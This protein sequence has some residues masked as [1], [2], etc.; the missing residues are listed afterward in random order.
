[1]T[2]VAVEQRQAR[3][4]VKPD[5]VVRAGDILYVPS[6]PAR[7]TLAG[8]VKGQLVSKGTGTI[9]VLGAAPTFDIRLDSD[10]ANLVPTSA[11]VIVTGPRGRW[12]AHIA[13]ATRSTDGGLDL[14][15]AG[16]SFD[17]CRERFSG[18]GRPSFLSIARGQPTNCTTTCMTNP[19]GLPDGERDAM[20]RKPS[21]SIRIRSP[22]P[23]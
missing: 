19:V 13:S 11:H 1:M 20:A 22:L 23:S 14:R 8:L 2:K 5:G 3:L 6:L 16:K 10:Q 15:L 9:N 12:D 18:R 21:D 4:G 17:S 7:I